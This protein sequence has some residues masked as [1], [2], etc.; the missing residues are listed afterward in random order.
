MANPF[1]QSAV[2][3][4]D[5]SVIVSDL[6]CLTEWVREAIA[7][8]MAQINSRLRGNTLYL[9]IETGT[10]Y[11][12]EQVALRLHQAFAKTPIET[13]LPAKSAP[14][15]RV[16]LYSRLPQQSKPVWMKTLELSAVSL[17]AVE[18]TMET[19][20]LA[21]SSTQN[22]A[23]QEQPE[24]I[25]RYLSQALIPFN[26]SIRTRVDQSTEPPFQRLLVACEA[27][28]SPEPS[29][30]AETIARSLRELELEGF[31]DAVMFAQVQG[32]TTPEWLLRVDLTP[33]DAM[34]RE[35]VHWGD[36][37]AIARLLN[38]I[39]LPQN[40]ETAALLKDVTLHL[41]CYGADR[42]P[43]DQLTVIAA[44][45]PLLKS[46]APQ[47]THA[48]ALYGVAGNASAPTTDQTPETP[49]WVHWLTL[50]AASQPERSL[51]TLELAQQGDLAA[52]TFLLTRLLNPDLDTCLATGGTRVQIRQ[53][54]D[55]LHIMTDAPTCPQQAEVTAVICKCLKPIAILGITGVRIYGRRSGQKVP[56]WS[57]GRD[58]VRRQRLVP[59]AVPEFSAAEVYL[60]ELLE[61]GGALVY[62]G[63]QNL[64][65]PQAQASSESAGRCQN[66]LAGFLQGVQRSLIRTQVFAPTPVGIETG[67]P[68]AAP[69]LRWQAPVALVWATVG[70]LLVIQTDW[71][72]GRW[73]QAPK[74][75]AIAAA[76]PTPLPL[77]SPS[78][79]LP[80]LK[81]SKAKAADPNAFNGSSFTQTAAPVA[82]TGATTPTSF[83]ASPLQLK[84]QVAIDYPTFNSRQLD[85]RFAIYRQY[86]QQNGTPDVLIIGSS[87]ALRGVDPAA[88]QTALKAP[89][90]RPLKVFNFGINGATAQVM[91]LLVRYLLPQESLPKLIVWADGAR[92][93]NSGR[94]D[95]TH[96]GIIASQGFQAVAA[97]SLPLPGTVTT[98]KPV[99]NQLPKGTTA[100]P[101]SLI[102]D[103]YQQADKQFNAA[104]STTSIV[105]S[106]RDRLKTQLRDR[107]VALLP[108]RLP[109]S[110]Q[111]ATALND[112][113]NSTSPAA[114]AA[115]ATAPVLSD[116]LG[117]SDYQ[118][119][120]PLAVRFN[121]TT[122]YQKYS[123]VPGDYDSD[124]E[125]FRLEGS[126]A[127]ALANL[128]QFTQTNQIQLVFV[129][130]PL[131]KDYLDPTRRQYEEQFQAQMQQ[132]AQQFG[133]VYRDLS[134]TF[135][136]Q[137]DYFSDPSHLNR[138]GGYVVSQRLASDALIPWGQL[139]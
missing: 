42:Q 113:S 101:Q 50:P 136:T 74:P 135:L 44:I 76:K 56:L 118:G 75:P 86:L 63:E 12:L 103:R 11:D 16:V 41:T 33:P 14:V 24:A 38:R 123:R 95:V 70:A 117:N 10:D 115:G 124:Y 62:Q 72:V 88:L 19:V 132:W 116:G 31:R 32:E 71:L 120:L 64:A 35:W 89:G 125:N 133:F 55:L 139:R 85:E 29:L 111:G 112:L 36:V 106:Q 78:A 2:D 83:L 91:D 98:A 99:G 82:V 90:S 27:T 84:S 97:G 105:Y 57:A 77:S 127:E 1:K 22:L 34:L 21:E 137:N 7:I 9:L 46:L 129:N 134:Q 109:I 20:L 131:T 59:E 47:G 54:S 17:A 39:L 108:P 23:H 18:S 58:F 40:I 93:F 28:F 102:S 107:L 66:A 51:T 119:F 79:P 60:G 6:A 65:Q 4:H 45:S 8:P 26:I 15:Y 122:Y 114:A 130:L 80:S 30:L 52:I 81:L 128:V 49:H 94:Q 138:Y 104:L 96:N 73:L 87:R 69:D 110:S 121:P 126:Q 68:V 100:M 43:P 37:Q 67:A 48:A 61:P 3:S 13:L 25:S 5:E 92:A 53:K